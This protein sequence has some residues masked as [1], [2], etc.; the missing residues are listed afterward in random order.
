MAPGLRE[1]EDISGLSGEHIHLMMK[2]SE[3][4]RNKKVQNCEYVKWRYVK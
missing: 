3:I 1:E 4:E 2:R